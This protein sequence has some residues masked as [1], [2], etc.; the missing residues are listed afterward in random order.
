MILHKTNQGL[1][2]SFQIWFRCVPSLSRICLLLFPLLSWVSLWELP[3]DKK[4]LF[5]WGL[6]NTSHHTCTKPVHLWLRA[7]ALARLYVSSRRETTFHNRYVTCSPRT[8]PRVLTE[9]P[10]KFSIFTSSWQATKTLYNT[11]LDARNP[12]GQRGQEQDTGDDS[13]LWHQQSSDWCH[14]D[15]GPS[16]PAPCRSTFATLPCQLSSGASSDALRSWGFWKY[17]LYRG[18]LLVFVKESHRYIIQDFLEQMNLGNV[19]WAAFE[20]GRQMPAAVLSRLAPHSPVPAPS[21]L[22]AE[23]GIGI[24]NI[25]PF[26]FI[27]PCLLAAS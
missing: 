18:S 4:T 8:N 19:S 16:W 7:D 3:R 22:P 5:L 27:S 17:A 21:A 26:I 25:C 1:S 23:T 14:P 24:A 12:H 6:P 15:P 11:S 13:V 2:P 9:P 10:W 20:G